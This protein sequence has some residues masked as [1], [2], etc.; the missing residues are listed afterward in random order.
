ML[1]TDPAQFE[2]DN[3][4]RQSNIEKHGIDFIDAVLIFDDP[5][6]FSYRSDRHSDEVRNVSVGNCQGRIVAVVWTRRGAKIRIISAR[7]ARRI[8]RGHYG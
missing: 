3:N 6:A 1:E 5:L 8:E 2:W 4:K 7:A